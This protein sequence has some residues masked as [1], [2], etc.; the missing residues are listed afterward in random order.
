M[1][2][3]MKKFSTYYFALN[4]AGRLCKFGGEIWARSWAEAESLASEGHTVDGEIIK[5]IP[6]SPEMNR[7]IE[8]EQARRDK[9]WASE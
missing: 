6:V 9:I 3:Q 2:V 8:R 1:S 4:G 5:E 7:A